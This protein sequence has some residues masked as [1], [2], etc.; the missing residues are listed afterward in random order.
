MET[1]MLT[2]WNQS[3]LRIKVSQRDESVDSLADE[4]LRG[5][6]SIRKKLSPKFFYDKTGSEL[7]EQIC[8]LPEYYP[9]RTERAI[10]LEY[11]DD[12]VR[13]LG[14]RI[15]LV[16]LGSGSAVKTRLIID[17]FSNRLPNLHYLPIDISKSALL[18]SSRSL[19]RD[20][21]ELTI[22][23]FVSDYHTALETLQEKHLG[24]KLILFLGSNIGNFEKSE[25]DHFLRKLCA[26]MSEDD[27]LLMGADLIKSKAIIEP[28]YNDKQGITAAF[29]LNLLKRLNRELGGDF[30]LT[31]FRHKAFLNQRLGRIEMHLE[32]L[33]KQMVA[34]EELDHRF[35]FA[36][37]ES[38]HTENSYKYS[39]QQIESLA[40]RNGFYLKKSWFDEKKWFS[41]NLLQPVDD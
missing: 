5:L 28:A 32:S 39:M 29:N 4:A 12:I 9:T 24:P 27:R 11:A 7:F 2:Q 6:T 30:D 40:G 23:G 34:I 36:K 15:V 21:P 22:T 20:Y 10:L 19:L 26:T 16:E 8:E 17:A 41:L 25:A 13:D 38:I 33:E 37:G 18:D 35:Y 1:E 14:T 31:K 3:R